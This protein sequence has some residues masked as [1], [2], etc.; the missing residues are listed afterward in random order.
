MARE[1]KE[2]KNFNT[3]Y[4]TN[5]DSR[6]VP[7]DAP[8]VSRN[9]DPN[10]PGGTLVGFKQDRY[11]GDSTNYSLYRISVGAFLAAAST[12][13]S[14]VFVLNNINPF[15]KGQYIAIGAYAY[16][17]FKIERAAKKLHV[18]RLY[19]VF[20]GGSVS[21]AIKTEVYY[22][23]LPTNIISYM[24]DSGAT[25][26]MENLIIFD[27][28]GTINGIRDFSSDV[29][30]TIGSGINTIGKIDSDFIN[31]PYE[32]AHSGKVHI[33]P[34][35]NGKSYYIAAGR[36]YKSQWL[37]KIPKASLLHTEGWVLED[38]EVYSPDNQSANNSY[39][40]I[41]TYQF[42]TATGGSDIVMPRLKSVTGV[43]H[44]GFIKAHNYLYIID[45][46]TGKTHKSMQFPFNIYGIAKVVSCK[47]DLRVWVYSRN[48]LVWNSHIENI[49]DKPGVISCYEIFDLNGSTDEIDLNQD[50]VFP[51]GVSTNLCQTIQCE[52]GR[53]KDS[54][55]P[56][57]PFY[58]KDNGAE[59]DFSGNPIISD[60]LETVD[61]SGNGKLW[62]LSSCDERGQSNDIGHAQNWFRV[63]KHLEGDDAI[64]ED[65]A[66]SN[67][68]MHRHLWCSFSN[69][70]GDT[71]D[72]SESTV[73]FNCKS[74]TLP[75][76]VDKGVVGNQSS[77]ALELTDKIGFWFKNYSSGG[78][79]D[80]GNVI[81]NTKLMKRSVPEASST[82]YTE[83]AG[84]LS[85]ALKDYDK[86]Y[87]IDGI[88]VSNPINWVA[89]HGGSY[90]IEDEQTFTSIA[91]I[92]AANER[93]KLHQ[94][95]DVTDVEII[96]RGENLG[97]VS[98]L[99]ST[100]LNISASS[101]PSVA[102]QI[103]MKA[104]TAY[105]NPLPYSL[106]DLSDLYDGVDHVVGCL[107]KISDQ[108]NPVF[109]ED[110][111][112]AHKQ[113]SNQFFTKGIRA[114]GMK[115][116]T[117]LW[118]S[119]GGRNNYGALY[120]RSNSFGYNT[121]DNSAETSFD[122]LNLSTLCYDNTDDVVRVMK[123]LGTD[124]PDSGI[125]SI[126]RNKTFSE[127]SGRSEGNDNSMMSS[128]LFITYKNR[129]TDS[130]SRLSGIG[131][132]VKLNTTLEQG[133]TIPT[134]IT[135][136]G[137]NPIPMITTG[138]D[139]LAGYANNGEL[140][141][142]HS[143][144]TITDNPGATDGV[145]ENPINALALTEIDGA[146]DIGDSPY[147]TGII[148]EDKYH[149]DD[150]GLS[151]DDSVAAVNTEVAIPA[152]PGVLST[153]VV[154]PI[155]SHSYHFMKIYYSEFHLS[156]GS[157]PNLR[158]VYTEHSTNVTIA[159]ASPLFLRSENFQNQVYP[160]VSSL[161][162]PIDLFTPE[163]DRLFGHFTSVR[164]II[165]PNI[166][167]ITNLSLD[168]SKDLIIGNV[169]SRGRPHTSSGTGAQLASGL[170]KHG[171]SY[172]YFT[173]FSK[174]S[175]EKI[176]YSALQDFTLFTDADDFRV[177]NLNQISNIGFR[178]KLEQNSQY[179]KQVL[180][181]FETGETTGATDGGGG[182][183]F[184][185]GYPR[186]F[187]INY[188]YDGYQNSPLS[189]SVYQFINTGTT[190]SELDITVKVPRDINRRI[191]AINI[192]IQGE[193]G[194]A[195]EYNTSY[196]EYSHLYH[197]ELQ[198]FKG[199]L[200]EKTN[201]DA[202][203]V[204]KL[205][206][207]Q[208][209]MAG[210]QTYKNYTGIPEDYRST[211]LDYE[212]SIPA[213]GYLFAANC[214]GPFIDEGNNILARSLDGQYSIFDS[215]PFKGNTLAFGDT[216]RALAYFQGSLYVF[217]LNETHRINPGLMT[218]EDVL[219]GFGCS[220]KDAVVVTEYGMFFAD[221][222]HVYHHDG[223]SVKII[224]YAIEN[225]VNNSL[226][227]R[228]IV[229]NNSL[230]KMYFLPKYSCIAIVSGATTTD[231][232]TYHVLKKRW[233]LRKLPIVQADGDQFNQLLQNNLMFNSKST[234]E[235][236]Y[237]I[238]PA[239]K[240]DNA[241]TQTSKIA[242]LSSDSEQYSGYRWHSKDFTMGSDNTD[243]RFLKLKIQ[244]SG[245]L[246][247]TPVVKIDG[248]TNTLTSSGTNE[249]KINANSGTGASVK[250]K[251]IQ[252]QMGTA[253]EGG[254]HNINTIIY[255][256]GIIYRTLKLK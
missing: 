75:S 155:F 104:E 188:E 37:G 176:Y 14:Y 101:D 224:S 201:G 35:G 41:I 232:L 237:F 92:D 40:K 234:E 166:K 127:Y 112:F 43:I 20:T 96:R 93:V 89:T 45:G 4:I 66:S 59:G 142:S 130:F 152:G 159:D 226:G 114:T 245:T 65:S 195:G 63:A 197:L 190:T 180:L 150:D 109:M 223:Q 253:S 230:F 10:A 158:A 228:N 203:Y 246:P 50:D 56:S 241:T 182:W 242:Q 236:Y 49:E 235:V 175:T 153:F 196:K 82:G 29:S 16:S 52:W 254:E 171:Y 48:P 2:I 238:N 191:S 136:A 74:M 140:C 170:S 169:W 83:S 8:V 208:S 51:Q 76:I 26:S 113:S 151:L 221:K 100:Q 177:N 97:M 77:S 129:L 218:R 148:L 124:I 119:N 108:S 70:D 98:G 54:G 215:S 162:S 73:Y 186:N 239:G 213:A 103:K 12:N 60:I 17:I 61:S 80:V 84:P 165:A 128:G 94:I 160:V 143:L 163:E 117:I 200:E 247:D 194:L 212:I 95:Y 67:Y 1:I 193:A 233:D 106:V 91:D 33:S 199:W 88:T 255:S 44:I 115:G 42:P 31:F 147:Q 145:Q 27:E 244:A 55:Y 198:N 120:N 149:A 116:K 139:G 105:F 137:T 6:D 5:A 209:K 185:T 217:L 168:E 78:G 28:Q 227:Y 189:D 164:R 69:I 102:A 111:W 85:G 131:L 79:D 250:G 62:L 121:N 25:S 211:N 32:I 240:G 46:D 57:S 141:S 179:S 3:G 36:N 122:D 251:K 183:S 19:G 222:N 34:G 134:S 248:L 22:L 214:K 118:V 71:S 172:Y 184:E 154:S 7:D 167:N 64:N 243:K 216:I 99:Y 256:I 210:M 220:N 144:S 138:R 192:W 9:I 174:G 206:H 87:T 58:S 15:S 204:N 202:Y 81:F 181:E 161:N 135:D 229:Y 107:I 24:R 18:N 178:F 225:D 38:S 90:W 125:L 30:G 21:L 133:D 47:T 205:V 39:D 207:G 219:E 68:D 132:A 86:T 110:M 72:V 252:V 156:G 123:V 23:P 173:L 231:I 13:Q 157:V 11:K 53:D 187:R 146:I 126:A 249:W